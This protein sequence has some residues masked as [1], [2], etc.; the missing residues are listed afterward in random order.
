[1]ENQNMYDD[2]TKFNE[3]LSSREKLYLDIKESIYN[4]LDE[5]CDKEINESRKKYITGLA[6]KAVL[7]ARR[8]KDEPR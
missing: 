2:I 5:I 7:N 6:A 1:M 8:Y 4:C 3:T